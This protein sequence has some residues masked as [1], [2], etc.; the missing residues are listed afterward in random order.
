[1]FDVSGFED[2]RIIQ[3]R[4]IDLRIVHPVTGVPTDILMR[5]AGPDSR[6][7][8]DARHELVDR[9]AK[10]SRANLDMAADREAASVEMLARAVLHWEGI[11]ERGSAIPFLHS[12]VVRVLTAYPWIREQVDAVAGSRQLFIAAVHQAAAEEAARQAAAGGDAPDAG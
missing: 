5:I 9:R 8:K 12:N 1:M 3:E 6:V 7:Q 2:L 4:G 11:A 10:Q